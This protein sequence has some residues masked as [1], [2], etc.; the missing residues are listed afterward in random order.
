MI[1]IC[2][3][4]SF[5]VLFSMRERTMPDKLT[6]V[7]RA[8]KWKIKFN[9]LNERNISFCHISLALTMCDL[10][11]FE[12][13][14]FKLSFNI[15][16]KQIRKINDSVS[17]GCVQRDLGLSFEG[18]YDFKIFM[19]REGEDSHLSFAANVLKF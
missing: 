1:D 9:I 6:H 2:I 11:S 10:T 17:F 8:M 12:V 4:L 13:H 14:N 15:K 19:S 3:F 16:I 18:D 5:F 7:L